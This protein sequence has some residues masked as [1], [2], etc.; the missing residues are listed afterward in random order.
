[1]GLLLLTFP[2]LLFLHLSQDVHGQPCF[3][4]GVTSNCSEASLYWSTLRVPVRGEDS[5]FS[6]TDRDPSTWLGRNKP[7]F[8]WDTYELSYRYK[9]GDRTVFYWS[10]PEEFLGSK[11]S[12]Y[13]GN[14]TIMQRAVGRGEPVQDSQV[15]MRGNGLTVHY[16]NGGE[17]QASGKEEMNQIMLKEDG[18]FV[19]DS[20]V[21]VPA[22]RE[23]FMKVLSNI[24]VTNNRLREVS[25]YKKR[26]NLETLWNSPHPTII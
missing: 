7:F 26:Y 3:C 19:L 6:I 20:G 10:L 4:S 25:K 2:F 9:P 16:G 12:A 23:E 22:T 15:I 13:G 11:L 14:L 8:K 18:W 5:G 21:P 17:S 1:M 24:E